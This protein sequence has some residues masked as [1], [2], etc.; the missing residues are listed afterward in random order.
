MKIS[1]RG[2][3]ALRML[4]DLAEHQGE[5]YV[6]LTD[7]A[8][9]QQI[10]KKYLEQIIPLLS[11]S[12]FLLT[13]RGMSGGYRLARD[14]SEYTVG[15]LL[16]LT[17]GS[18]APTSCLK[19]DPN[20]CEMYEQCRSICVWEGLLKVMTDYLDSLTLQDVLEQ[21]KRRVLQIRPIDH[22]QGG[23]RHIC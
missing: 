17:E 18:L 8:E 22:T 7:I 3:Y 21:N 13:V 12:N 9:R 23:R 19:N 1:T 15:E 5:G 6:S 14:P 20:E 4:L 2:R 16:R 10:S 11:K